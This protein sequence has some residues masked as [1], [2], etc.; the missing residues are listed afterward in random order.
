MDIVLSW[1][2]RLR[3]YH[4]RLTKPRR[5]ILDVL[6]KTGEHL[7]A[8]EIYQRVYQKYPGIGLTTVYRTLELLVQLGLVLKF[9]FG[10]GRSRYELY[11]EMGSRKG[12]HHHLICAKC[13]RVID[14]TDFV[15]EE[16]EFLKKTER[17]LEK[18]YH[19]H[20]TNHVIAFYGICEDCQQKEKAIEKQSLEI[21]EKE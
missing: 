19:F 1:E 6:K 18:R 10:D 20:I 16:R 7:S 4:Y 2:K 8:E 12:H 21:P 17:A 11:E 13:H 3:E 9:E 14:Y 15:D 5:S